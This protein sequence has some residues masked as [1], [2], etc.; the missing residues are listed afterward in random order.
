MGIAGCTRIEDEVTL[1]GQVGVTSAIRIGKGA[2][3]SAQSGVSKS[4]EGGKS[5]FGSPAGEARERLKELAA[6]RQMPAVMEQLK[7][8]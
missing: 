1:W 3:V 2:V 6:L 4:L 5:Y 7:K 8:A